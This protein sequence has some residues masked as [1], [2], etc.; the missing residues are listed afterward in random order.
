[1]TSERT[2]KILEHTADKGILAQGKTMGEAF[3]TAAYGMFSLFVNLSNYTPNAHYDIQI[4]ADDREQLL[5]KWL[6]DLL[7]VFEAEK[8][9][10]IDS[11]ITEIDDTHLCARVYYLPVSDNIEFHG[12]NVKAVTFHKLEV[13][14]EDSG[15]H[16]QV[17]FDV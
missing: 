3:E 5:Y 13:V 17:Y 11:K 12:S 14:E 16:V 10:P 6:S 2:F 15:W 9:L 1:M 7:F 4:H 8:R